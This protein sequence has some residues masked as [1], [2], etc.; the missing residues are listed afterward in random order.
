MPLF[1]L[2]NLALQGC[3]IQWNDDLSTKILS[4]FTPQ[5]DILV[6]VHDFFTFTN[7]DD[8]FTFSN[9]LVSNKNFQSIQ[10]DRGVEIRLN[11][12]LLYSENAEYMLEK[13]DFFKLVNQLFYVLIEGAVEHHHTVRYDSKWHDFIL[14]YE[15]VKGTL[16]S[17]SLA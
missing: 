15:H 9:T 11:T 5:N 12:Y 8:V 1:T 14:N 16:S 17:L 4:T 13:E 7:W 2:D 10:N 6:A 3:D